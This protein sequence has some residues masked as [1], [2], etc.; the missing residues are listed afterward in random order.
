[1]SNPKALPHPA[2]DQYEV[3]AL[4]RGSSRARRDQEN[5]VEKD[6]VSPKRKRKKTQTSLQK[7]KDDYDVVKHKH[8]LLLVHAPTN[9]EVGELISLMMELG[10]YDFMQMFDLVCALS[11]SGR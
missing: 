11:F 1:M 9:Y 10:F 3:I 7:V 5:E 4:N 6:V 8:L 2:R